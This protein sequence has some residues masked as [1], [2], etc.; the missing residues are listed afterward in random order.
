MRILF[1]C[2]GGQTNGNSPSELLA[3]EVG[4]ISENVSVEIFNERFNS[5]SG[6]KGFDLVWGD[7]DGSGVL[8]KALAAAKKMRVPCYLHGEWIP[9]YRWE[10]GWSKEFNEP[11]KLDMKP[12]Y[13]R[14]IKAMRQADLVSL[15]LSST[16]GGFEWL[17]ERGVEFENPF[18]RYP[19]FK[20]QDLLTPPLDEVKVCTV[21]RLADGKKRVA[22][23]LK[24]LE[25]SKMRPIFETIGQGSVR[26]DVIEVRNRGSFNDDRK[27]QT[28]ASSAIAIQHWSGIPPAEAMMQG[29][30]VI[31]YDIPYMRELY[32]D[33]LIWVEKDNIEQLS[34]KIDTLLGDSSTLL[35]ADKGF[36]GR[37]RL[38]SGKL[39]V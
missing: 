20:K 35:E 29:T 18:V 13:E 26:S 25:A 21:A 10:A 7:M 11:T 30:P 39:N 27:H 23:T 15:A 5:Y 34:Y 37:E 28:Y 4:S 6:Q 38:L 22:H 8:N 33:S 9:P 19:S 14:N 17:A 1:M 2:P 3:K 16:P 36:S 31:S 24:A 32:A 12:I